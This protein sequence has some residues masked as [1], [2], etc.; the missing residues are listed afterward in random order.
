MSTLTAA[1]FHIPNSLQLQVNQMQT[2][3]FSQVGR[4]LDKR[5]SNLN[6]LCSS[7]SSSQAV[8]EL[9]HITGNN[10]SSLCVRCLPSGLSPLWGLTH[11]RKAK[12]TASW[13]RGL[14][15]K[16]SGTFLSTAKLKS[17]AY[18]IQFRAEWVCS[19]R[20]IALLCSAE[21]KLSMLCFRSLWYRRMMMCLK[22][23]QFCLQE[24][25][26]AQQPLAP[27]CVLQSVKSL[28]K[29]LLLYPEWSFSEILPQYFDTLLF[30]FLLCF[31]KTSQLWVL[32]QANSKLLHGFW[33]LVF[34]MAWTKP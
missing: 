19:L 16:F 12:T 9:C 5:G 1:R 24:R 17:T 27:K 33:Q 4:Q 26:M 13:R 8:T 21:K 23:T 29:I 30:A 25:E 3:S 18:L 32:K 11:K 34:Q 22:E 2:R 15:P 20:W 10:D 28:E 31:K 7:A 14:W 6:Q